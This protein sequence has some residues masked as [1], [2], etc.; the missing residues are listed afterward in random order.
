MKIKFNYIPAS[1]FSQTRDRGR[2]LTF[3][4]SARILDREYHILTLNEVKKR[5]II[6]KC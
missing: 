3:N 1:G 5:G 4:I 2:A 6:W